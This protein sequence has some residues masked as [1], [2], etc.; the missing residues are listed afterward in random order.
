ME[1]P[2][3][4]EYSLYGAIVNLSARLMEAAWKAGTRVHCDDNARKDC[5]ARICWAEHSLSLVCKG[6]PLPCAAHV[7][8]EVASVE[9]PRKLSVLMPP[10][11]LQQAY[12]KVTGEVHPTSDKEDRASPSPTSAPSPASPS[13]WSAPESISLA[14]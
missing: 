7:P 13:S 2:E 6:K 5:A 10:S 11:T 8:K 4:L 3:R 9:Q 12:S 1:S 14:L